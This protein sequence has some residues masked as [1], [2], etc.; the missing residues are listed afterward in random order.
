MDE[1]TRRKFSIGVAEEI[2]LLNEASEQTLL[3]NLSHMKKHYWMI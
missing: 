2:H 1:P 3:E